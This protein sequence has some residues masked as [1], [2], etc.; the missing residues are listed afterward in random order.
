MGRKDGTSCKGN[1]PLRITHLFRIL[2][3]LM[4]LHIH[5]RKQGVLFPCLGER[6]GLME[7]ASVRIA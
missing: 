5:L 1:E 2:K 3:I 6:G 4:K 7:T